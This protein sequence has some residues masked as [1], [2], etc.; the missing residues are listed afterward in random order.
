MRLAAS[1][2][3]PSTSEYLSSTYADADGFTLGR[4]PRRSV[5]TA[6]WYRFE[7]R[8]QRHR[9][10]FPSQSG[11]R[12][13]EMLAFTIIFFHLNNERGDW[14]VVAVSFRVERSSSLNGPK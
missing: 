4:P 9:P 6:V 3:S 14:L 10:I 1:A 12:Y 5:E 7:R 8:M 11:S 13:S 2:R